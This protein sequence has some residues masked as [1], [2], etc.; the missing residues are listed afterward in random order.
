MHSKDEKRFAVIGAGYYA[1]LQ[2][3]A[4]LEVK[5]AKLMALCNRTISKAEDLAKKYDIPGVYDDAEKMLINEKLDFVDIITHTSTHAGYVYLAAKYKLP[6]ICQKPMALDYETCKSMVQACMDHGVPFMIHENFRWQLPKR[7]VKQ[8][9]DEG[10]IGKPY[11]AHLQLSTGG[12]EAFVN[13]PGLKTLEN[14]ALA[15]MGTHLFDLARFFFGEPQNV[16]CQTY[17]SLKDIKGDNVVC[18]MLGFD[19]LICTCEISDAISYG[20]FIEGEKGWLELRT[21]DSIHINTVEGT[22]IR[23]FPS[24]HH[25]WASDYVVKRHGPDRIHGI[26]ECNNSLFKSIRTGQPAETSAE[27]TLKTMR[28]IFAALESS[29]SNKVIGLK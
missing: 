1:S 15:D 5:G 8:I 22:T 29:K 12:A 6:V 4:W 26:V 24:P 17:R 9:L 27:E 16:Y 19:N 28:I 25:S 10:I 23:N 13:E 14:Y 7:G 21:D 11:R 20:V 2:I 18:S 3:P